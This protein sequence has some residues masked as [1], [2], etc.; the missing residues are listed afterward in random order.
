MS[1]TRAAVRVV[2]VDDHAVVR[3]GYRRLLERTGDITVIA[4]AST[5][6][7]AYRVV[8][9][10]QPDV[11]VM[12]INLPGIGGI[13][14]VRRI[15]SRL[16]EARI[17]MFSMHEDTVFSSR[18][19]QAGARG[20]VTKSAAPEV[21]VEAVRLVAAGKLYI[22]HEMAQELAVQMLPGRDNPIDALSAREFEVFRLLV[23]GHSLQ[24]IS[25]IL[26]LSYK[27][28]ANY[29]SNIKHKLDVSNSA[30][31]VRIA[32]NHGL[33]ASRVE[34]EEAAEQG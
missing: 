12:D 10:M 20:Y 9:E 7:E 16:P 29:Q 11:T 23:A 27:T 2:L 26:C 18:A 3:E 13:E 28:V 31:V 24:E 4:E 19:L 6:E 15:V 22:S 34:T 21:L 33:I 1:E 25:R 30:Q 14:V 8:S 17:L 32:L 5:G